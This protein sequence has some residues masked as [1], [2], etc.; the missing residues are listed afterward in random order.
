MNR[1]KVMMLI[2]VGSETFFFLSLIISYVVYSH[3]GGTLAATAKYLDIKTASIFTF[4]LLASSFTLEMAITKR[5]K[6]NR[7]L[8]L[9]WLFI[10]ITFGIIFLAGQSYEYYNLYKSDITISR[11]IFGSAF[12]TLTGFHG[13]HVFIGL[14]VLSIVFLIFFLNKYESVETSALESA[15]VYWHFVDAVWILVFSVVYIG[16]SI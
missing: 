10:T 5:S 2:F 12:F 8:Q 6:T 16:A 1:N 15:S 4:F 11:D 7:R 9:L 13:F 14:I 3:P